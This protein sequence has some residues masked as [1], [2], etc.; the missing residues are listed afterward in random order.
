MTYIGANGRRKPGGYLRA[1]LILAIC[2][3][4]AYSALITLFPVELHQTGQW[5]HAKMDAL[6]K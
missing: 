2:L 1:L 5:L 3:G 6:L 4:A